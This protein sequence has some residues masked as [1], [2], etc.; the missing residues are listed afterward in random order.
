[1]FV[2]KRG[3]DAQDVQGVQQVDF[4]ALPK[5][6]NIEN[7]DNSNLAIYEINY[8]DGNQQKKVY[9]ITYSVEQLRA[10]G[11]LIVAHDNRNFLDFGH[12]GI[13]KETGFLETATG[14][15]TSGAKGYVMVRDGSITAIS[16]NL[17]IMQSNSGQIDIVVL[18]NGQAIS[19]GNTISTDSIGVKKDYDVQSNDI[20]S[21]K[22]GDVISVL[23]N[24]NGEVAWNDVIT[25]V[26]IT[27]VN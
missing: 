21:F 15:E 24:K 18:K 11:D 8:T 20:V 3:I 6:V 14:V 10:Q 7:I 1:D 16:T 23:V 25:M 12:S 27:T 5:E 26:E 22:A 2:S 9:M 17:E 4:N 19:F 13:M